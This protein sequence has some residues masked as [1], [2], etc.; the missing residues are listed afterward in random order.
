MAP[1]DFP[2]SPSPASGCWDKEFDIMLSETANVDLL[3]SGPKLPSS[4]SSS[5][6]SSS[7]SSSSDVDP[8]M[9]ALEKPEDDHSERPLNLTAVDERP[10]TA[11]VYCANQCLR[12]VSLL[13]MWLIRVQDV[14]VIARLATSLGPWM[15]SQRLS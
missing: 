4:S 8:D 15:C 5:D 6:S 10:N 1:D 2:E 7:S 11:E 3:F 13:V 12:R 9:P 14:L